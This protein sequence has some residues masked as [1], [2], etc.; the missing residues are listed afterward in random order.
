MRQ[1]DTVLFD[2]DGTLV[3]SIP[4]IRNTL[5]RTIGEFFPGIPI[6]PSVLEAMIGP[7]L[8]ES[9]ARY[10]NRPDV[11]E[12]MIVRYREL[13]VENEPTSIRIFPGV[14]E[15]LTEMKHRGYRLGIVTTKF[16]V[17]AM[18][19]L[20]LFGIDRMFDVLVGLE[21]VKHHKPH[22]EPVMMALG[23]SSPERAV[24]VGDTESDLLAG[25]AAGT[26]VCAVGWSHR[27][28]ALRALNPDF[29][30]DDFAELIPAIEK[31]DIKENE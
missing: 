14:S 4:L 8:S 22:P 9:F 18:P 21:H 30:I 1:I 11:I 3:D 16:T 23:S 31:H 29:W 20:S 5:Q 19:S 24:M 2:L 12:H 27:R 25:R 10:T 7:P 6:E 13:Y 28:E 17:S 15:T 26:L